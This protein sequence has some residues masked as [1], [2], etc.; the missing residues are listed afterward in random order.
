MIITV[1]IDTETGQVT[2]DRVSLD[3]HAVEPA[4]APEPASSSEGQLEAEDDG[5]ELEP[6]AQVIAMAPPPR[7][8]PRVAGSPGDT[9]LQDRIVDAMARMLLEKQNMVAA[10]KAEKA[11]GAA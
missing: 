10:L 2:V 9:A 8:A 5:F 11:K 6:M 3:G 4:P 7:V 1:H